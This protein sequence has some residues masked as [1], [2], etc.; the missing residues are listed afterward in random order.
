MIFFIQII[1]PDKQYSDS[2][3]RPLQPVPAFSAYE[4]SNGLFMD[5]FDLYVLDQF[6]LRDQFRTAK[7]T[8]E[9][10]V[11]L[12]KDCNDIY[13]A[14]GH[15]S[16]MIYPL[17]EKMLQHASERFSYLYENYFN[18]KGWT[19]YFIIVPDK[20]YYLAE[21]ND[22]LSLPYDEL[23]SY[24]ENSNDNMKFIDIRERLELDDYYFTDT[25][26]KQENLTD[27]SEFIVSEMNPDILL[28]PVEYTMNTLS[29]PFYGVYYGQAALPHKPDEMHYLTNETLK[30]C[31]VTYFD[32]KKEPVSADMYDFN[33]AK[34]KDPYELFLSGTM[35]LITMDNPSSQS[36]RTLLMF[37][38]SFGSSLAPL[39][40]P[41]YERIIMIDIRYM[42]SDVLGNYVPFE[43]LSEENTDVLFLYSTYL[44]N[45]SMSLS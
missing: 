19:P 8:F 4:L 9:K 17:N 1:L 31:T 10:Y 25:H 22:Y 26:W 29:E 12:K 7:A 42:K 30:N 34:G 14:D 20:N 39:L 23:Y 2:E 40:V 27:L 36:D 37:R 11:F 24:M 35:P 32:G 43:S 33:K 13:E 3:R 28:K 16:K 38:D 18:D 41:Y 44:L 6:P 21:K 45:D 5:C 15:L